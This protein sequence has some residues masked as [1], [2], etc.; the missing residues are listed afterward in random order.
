MDVSYLALL[1]VV[2]AISTF[3]FWPKKKPQPVTRE[4]FLEEL[5]VTVRR[6]VNSHTYPI[7]TVEETGT[8]IRI[9]EPVST[10]K[11]PVIA[12]WL[13]NE[14]LPSDRNLI[15]MSWVGASLP[16]KFSMDDGGIVALLTDL[17]E[18]LKTFH[19]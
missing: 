12:I 17:R 19:R 9:L 16:A 1:A 2:L 18:C 8:Q 4:E 10:G 5:A 11:Q 15:K 3:L 14:N 6:V 7:L 13:G